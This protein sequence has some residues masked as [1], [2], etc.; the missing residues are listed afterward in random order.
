MLTAFFERVC[1]WRNGRKR[2][3]TM[4]IEGDYNNGVDQFGNYPPTERS[5][6]QQQNEDQEKEGTGLRR[7]F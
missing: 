3:T 7:F 5:E 4:R 2:T 6:N 1:F